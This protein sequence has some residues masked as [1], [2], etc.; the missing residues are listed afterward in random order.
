MT[1][2]GRQEWGQSNDFDP[3]PR[4]ILSDIFRPDTCLLSPYSPSFG[5]GPPDEPTQIY[6]FTIK[7]GQWTPVTTPDF[8]QFE[9]D[10]E[11]KDHAL[12]QFTP[13][14]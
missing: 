3:V 8:T 12:I 6:Y 2:C 11:M 4:Q 13:Q 9:K 5:K 7:E 1:E 14:T 10:T